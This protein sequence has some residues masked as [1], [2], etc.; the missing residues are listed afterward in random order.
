MISPVYIRTISSVMK[1]KGYCK[2]G[3]KE[4]ETDA[5]M[6]YISLMGQ[7]KIVTFLMSWSPGSP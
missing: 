6:Y 1:V 5:K 7:Y 2:I 4:P 3:E